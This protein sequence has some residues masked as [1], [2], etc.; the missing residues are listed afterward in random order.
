[1]EG[2]L[3]PTDFRFSFWQSFFEGWDATKKKDKAKGGRQE[4]LPP[5]EFWGRALGLGQWVGGNRKGNS[6]SEPFIVCH[7]PSCV[8]SITPIISLTS[9]NNL[10][11]WNII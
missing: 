9:L 6:Q 5:C 10:V 4:P 3:S 1:M 8:L 2:F 7:M 11:K